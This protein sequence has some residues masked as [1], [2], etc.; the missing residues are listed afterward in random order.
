MR[1]VAYRLFWVA[2]WLAPA[3]VV[4]WGL[5]FTCLPILSGWSKPNSLESRIAFFKKN[6]EVFDSYIAR[7]ERGEVKSGNYG[8]AIPQLLIDNDVKEVVRR[9]DCVQI[10]FWFMCTDAVPFYIYSPRGLEGV[11]D[12]MKTGGNSE[13]GKL[14]YWKF[15]PI[16]D[17]WFYCEW[18]M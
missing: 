12:E 17:K 13:Y 9:G 11:P 5:Q 14:S 7:L 3:F 8:Y 15:V 1:T 10:T 18:D 6:R 16:D 4:L 2:A